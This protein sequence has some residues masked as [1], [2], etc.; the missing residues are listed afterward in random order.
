MGKVSDLSLTFL[1]RI[2]WSGVLVGFM[3]PV[4]VE[5]GLPLVYPM[6]QNPAAKSFLAALIPH[7]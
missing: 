4:L 2:F 6:N 5:Q 7:F 1:F 3:K